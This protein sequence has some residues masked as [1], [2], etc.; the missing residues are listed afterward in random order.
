MVS[1][2]TVRNPWDRLISGFIGK[3]V[4]NEKPIWRHVASYFHLERRELITFAHYVRFVAARP[5]LDVHWTPHSDVCQ[6]A[7][8][9]YAR[10]LRVEAL[11][12]DLQKLLSDLGWADAAADLLDFERISSTKTCHRRSACHPFLPLLNTSTQAERRRNFF[13]SEDLV[14]LVYATFADD[15]ASGGYSF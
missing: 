3:I 14:D 15:I 9:A 2:T 11:T 12:E 5:E 10:T 8:H 13:D 6:S 1:F 7:Y 4:C